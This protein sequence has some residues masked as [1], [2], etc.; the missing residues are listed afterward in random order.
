[1]HYKYCIDMD[2]DSLQ[3]IIKEMK[4]MINLVEKP[5]IIKQKY[6]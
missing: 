6:K 1:M 2:M 3:M 4:K 5:G